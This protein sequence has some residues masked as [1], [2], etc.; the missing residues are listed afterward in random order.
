MVY[1]LFGLKLTNPTSELFKKSYQY[2]LRLLLKDIYL[3]INNK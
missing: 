1:D 2:S 3:L